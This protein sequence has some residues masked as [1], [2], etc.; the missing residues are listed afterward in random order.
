MLND[1]KN[2]LT[3]PF[4]VE[5]LDNAFTEG[6]LTIGKKYMVGQTTTSGEFYW[7]QNDKGIVGCYMNLR[8]RKVEDN[9]DNDPSSQDSDAG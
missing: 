7:L 5:C 6:A 8:F 3:T 2:K 1:E 4:V 9:A